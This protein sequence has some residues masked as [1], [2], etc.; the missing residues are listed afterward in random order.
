MRHD[1]TQLE[2]QQ[3]V[4]HTC[5][6]T[7]QTRPRSKCPGLTLY[8]KYGHEPLLTKLQL[9]YAGYEISTKSLP[10]AVG[11]Y[12]SNGKYMLL[13]DPTQAIKKQTKRR[14]GITRSIS[15]LHWPLTCV[16]FI[17]AYLRIDSF[18]RQA[19]LADIAF[20]L[21]AFTTSE[22]EQFA[23]RTLR[24]EIAPCLVHRS[25]QAFQNASPQ[26]AVLVKSIMAAYE[27]CKD[28]VAL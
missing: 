7:W 2:T 22:I 6:Q 17:E 1:L 20:H 27:K 9:G 14:A 15:E 18:S 13:Y 26:Q 12:R 19:E 25:Y 4:C 8:P 3:Y 10:P 28:E 11:C 5:C 24:L 16:P 21:S 23:G